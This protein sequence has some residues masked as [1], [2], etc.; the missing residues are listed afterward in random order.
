VGIQTVLVCLVAA[1]AVLYLGRSAWR[2]W[3][4]KSC[5]SCGCGSKK[6]QEGPGLISTESLSARL[7][8][9]GTSGDRAG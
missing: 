4:G 2:T 6:K 5:G 8:E 1:A 3:A 9:R 7:R